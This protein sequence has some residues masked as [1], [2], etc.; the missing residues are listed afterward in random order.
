MSKPSSYLLCATPRSGS[1]L[2]CDLLKDTGLAGAPNS[3]YRQLSIP[4]WV[5][6]WGITVSESDPAFD[7]IYLEAARRIGTAGTGMF[8]MRLMWNSVDDMLARFAGL[9]PDAQG[10]AALIDM[11]FGPTR[12]V[13]LR[14]E[15]RLA[16]AI[17]RTRAEQGGLWHVNADGSERERIKSAPMVYDRA[18]IATYL[19]EAE[20]DNSKWEDWFASNRIEPFR[21]SYEQLSA[22]PSSAIAGVLAFLGSDPSGAAQLRPRTR[23]LADAQSRDWAERFKAEAAGT[24]LFSSHGSD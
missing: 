16:Q 21:L 22:D 6:D 23:K 3:F 19:A 13:Y 4:D 12:Y 11:A 9:F 10:D 5:A 8:G 14:R 1:T 15:D 17:S 18:R 7:R 2:L 24:D 20:A